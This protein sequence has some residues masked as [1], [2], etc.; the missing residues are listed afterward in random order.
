MT[1]QVECKICRNL[2]DRDEAFEPL[3]STLI[4][5]PDHYPECYAEFNDREYIRSEFYD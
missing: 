3:E 1:E 5:H 2:I 4:C